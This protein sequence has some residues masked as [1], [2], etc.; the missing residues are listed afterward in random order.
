VLTDIQMPVMDGIEELVAIRE[1]EKTNHLR[2]TPVVAITADSRPEARV[3]LAQMGF[4]GIL[5]KPLRKADL[6]A[7]IGQEFESLPP[8]ELSASLPDLV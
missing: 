1:W 4:K 3:N 8:I 2:E 7:W 5:I 6:L